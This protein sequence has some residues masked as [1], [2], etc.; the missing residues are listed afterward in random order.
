MLNS[1]EF[2]CHTPTYSRNRSLLLQKGHDC[3]SCNGPNTYLLEFRGLSQDHILSVSVSQ[4][5]SCILLGR[6]SNMETECSLR[7]CSLKTKSI[8]GL[9]LVLVLTWSCPALVMS[10]NRSQPLK[11]LILSLPVS[12]H[13]GLDNDYNAG[14]KIQFNI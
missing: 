14:H 4:H 13:F 3:Q 7:N 6:W 9:P 2:T 5:L 11:V 8:V 12:M 10:L 1:D